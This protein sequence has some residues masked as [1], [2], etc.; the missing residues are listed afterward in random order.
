MRELYVWYRVAPAQ[1]AAA[2]R[3]VLALQAELRADTPGLVARL[4]I[5]AE[6][7]GPVQTWMESYALPESG[8]GIGSALEAVIA[9]RALIAV[10]FI[11]G[12]RHAEA[13]LAD[14]G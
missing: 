4:L 11:D 6:P 1:A 14:R 10:P 3:A 12:E 5:R 9:D 13:F 8:H 7:G 2:R